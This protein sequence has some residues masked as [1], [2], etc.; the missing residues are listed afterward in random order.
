MCIP[1]ASAEVARRTDKSLKLNISNLIDVDRIFHPD[2]RDPY[3]FPHL[4]VSVQLLVSFIQACGGRDAISDFSTSAICE[5]FVKPFTEPY[6]VSCC[7]LLYQSNY[8]GVGPAKVFISHAWK[9]KFVDVVDAILRKFSD[10]L[11]VVVWFDV[12]SVNQH[13]TGEK[14]FSWWSGTFQ[15]A[16]KRFG[17][18]VMVLSPWH[19]PQPLTR[20]WCLWELYCTVVTECKFEVAFSRKDEEL[21]FNEVS[22][23]SLNAMKA[24]INVE[25][26]Q[27]WKEEDKQKIFAAIREKTSF[28]KLNSEVFNCLRTWMTNQLVIANEKNNDE[29]IKNLFKLVEVHFNNGN[30]YA[31]QPLMERCLEL[32]KRI[33]GDEH[34]ETLNYMHYLPRV[35]NKQ[36]KFQEAEELYIECL[37]KKKSILGD[38]H[39]STLRTMNNLALVYD[40]QQKYL[41]AEKVY[42]ECL[43]MRKVALGDIHRDTLDTMHNLAIVYNKQARCEEAEQLYLVCIAGRSSVLGPRHPDTLR[44]MNCLAIVY[45][46]QGKYGEAETLYHDCL[47]IQVAVLG[48]RH[49]DTLRTMNNLAA[50]YE[51]QT[52]FDEADKLFQECLEMQKAVLGDRHPDTLKTMNSYQAFREKR[53]GNENR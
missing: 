28:Q 47:E 15:E 9:Y 52:K 19:D 5:R 45:N 25:N 10:S 29:D 18:T 53:E 12:F 13:S 43:E 33:L 20:A 44:T 17:H 27:C 31:A 22:D 40:N 14:D 51:K 42:Q 41:Q 21:F 26:S 32:S 36:G 6:K 2:E 24:K 39:P 49:P 7:D 48:D 11:D 46:T 37:A 8:P 30:Y 3:Y 50:L 23:R 38:G 35:Y 34:E 1:C 16:I 4:G